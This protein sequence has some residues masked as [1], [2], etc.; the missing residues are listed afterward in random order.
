MSYQG[1]E[2]GLY[3]AKQSSEKLSS[4]IQHFGIIDV[5]NRFNHQQAN[6]SHPIVYHKTLE[7]IQINW[8]Q[9][10]GLW[11]IIEKITD[12]KKANQMLLKALENPD[13]DLF[14]NNCEHF[15]NMIAKGKKESKQLQAVGW[16]A[17]LAVITIIGLSDE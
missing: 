11:D 2:D 16:I 5:G 6:G 10:T 15:A 12:E 14:S 17:G 4:V 3:L 13:Y 7:G 1:F 8:L 9:D